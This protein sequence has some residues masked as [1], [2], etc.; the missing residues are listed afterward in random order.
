[1]AQSC[2]DLTGQMSSGTNNSTTGFKYREVDLRDTL[3][4]QRVYIMDSNCFI[5]AIVVLLLILS[6]NKTAK[7]VRSYLSYI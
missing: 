3:N 6:Q 1:M 4:L 7:T 2:V 5:I